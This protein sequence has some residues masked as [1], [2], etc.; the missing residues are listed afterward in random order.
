[1]TANAGAS[2][3]RMTLPMALRC[4][5]LPF[6]AVLALLPT[7]AF[8]E[9]KAPQT[10]TVLVFNDPVA[11]QEDEFNRWY[12]EEHLPDVLAVPGFFSGQRFRRSSEQLLDKPSASSGYLTV[13]TIV[14]DDL[15]AVFAELHR[16]GE[17]GMIS[18]SPSVSRDFGPNLTYRVTDAVGAGVP[19]NATAEQHAFRQVVLADA[20]P[21]EEAAVDQW[22]R[23]FHAPEIAAFPGFTGYRL[24]NLAAEQMV[25]NTGAYHMALFNIDTADLAPAQALFHDPPPM[26]KGPGTRNLF[27]VVYEAIGPLLLAD[28]VRQR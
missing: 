1:M 7:C 9:E 22:Y 6:V 23:D 15:P 26:T 27:S 28:E 13:F 3:Q 17:K 2:G 10:Y 12:D 14:T 5:L 18:L 25:A 16:R 20:D 24:G 11:G 21:G 19:G 8:A 4:L